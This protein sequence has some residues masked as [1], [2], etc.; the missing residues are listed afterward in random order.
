VLREVGI[1]L[2]GNLDLAVGGEL[3]RPQADLLVADDLEAHAPLHV[4]LQLT[5]VLLPFLLL[6]GAGH[7]HQG[8][9]LEEPGFG[10]EVDAE[11][12]GLRVGLFRV[13]ALDHR[14]DQVR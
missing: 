12:L 6:D 7:A 8:I 5:A 4:D 9:A 3:D 13:E 14:T 11:E 10:T 2:G 1:E